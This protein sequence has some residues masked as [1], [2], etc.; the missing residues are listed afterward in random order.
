MELS[1]YDSEIKISKK[2]RKHGMCKIDFLN[3]GKCTPGDKKIFA[4]YYPFGRLKIFEKFVNGEIP[5]TDTLKDIIDSCTFCG[6]CNIQCYFLMEMIPQ[7]VMVAMKQVLKE[8][9]KHE[10]I[11][12]IE[13]DEVLENLRNIV[14]KG[15]AT[16]DPAILAAYSSVG[17]L[18]TLER[19]PSYVVAPETTEETAKIVKIANHYSLQFLPISTGSN[20]SMLAIDNGILIDLNRMK[21]LQIDRFNYCAE[22]GAGIRAFDLQKAAMEKGLRMS[23]GESSAGVCANQVTSG[24]HSL[25]S[26]RYGLMADLFIEAELVTNDGTIIHTSS[27]EAPNLINNSHFQFEPRIPYICTKLKLRLFEVELDETIIIIP[28]KEM[29][30]SLSVMKKI[31]KKTIGKAMGLTSVEC[32]SS[33]L[34]LTIEDEENFLDIAKD[35]LKINYGLLIILNQYELDYLKKEYPDLT[36]LSHET[37]KKIILGIPAITGPESMFLVES[38]MDEER[39]YEILFGEMLDYFLQKIEMSPEEVSDLLSGVDDEILHK[40]LC[41]L[42]FKPEF[43]DIQ[44]WFNYRIISPRM[45]RKLHFFP[46]LLFTTF[47]DFELLEEIIQQYK[48]ISKKYK[49]ENHLCYI[50]PIDE[51]KRLSIEYDFFYDQ[52]DSSMIGDLRKTAFVNAHMTDKMEKKEKGF[53]PGMQTYYKGFMNKDLFLYK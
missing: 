32:L 44:Y 50:V 22:V 47:D 2:C 24:F 16:N 35:Y 31:S 17:A 34:C 19:I 48:K 42:Y 13:T 37:L 29:K 12:E 40:A 53:Y 5:L 15:W 36:F 28:F 10:K 26:Y 9:L 1:Q 3:T 38:V 27:I 43:S 49:I 4:A 20:M 25:F 6:H 39:P 45:N 8:R 30:Q 7:K 21:T 11:I 18:S 14:G 46:N 23:I 41:D 52:N 33:V 51:G